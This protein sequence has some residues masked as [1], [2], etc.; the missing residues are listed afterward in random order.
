MRQFALLAAFSCCMFLLADAA[1]AH[2][3]AGAGYVPAGGSTPSWATNYG[4]R[5]AS[6]T[7]GAAQRFTPRTNPTGRTTMQ[8]RGRT[9]MSPRAKKNGTA[10]YWFGAVRLRWEG[11]FLPRPTGGGYESRELAFDEAV[12]G[13][14]GDSSWKLKDRPTLIMVYD[15]SSKKDINLAGLVE[16]NTDFVAASKFFNL[17]RIDRRSIQ[18]KKLAKKFKKEARFLLY[19]AKGVPAGSVRDNGTARKLIAAMKPIISKDYGTKASKAIAN[20]ATVLSRKAW[21]KETIRINEHNVIC[22]D[23]GKKDERVT[24]RLVKLRQALVDLKSKERGLLVRG[25]E[26]AAR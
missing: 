4:I 8:P 26:V 13:L 1:V 16:Q 24:G 23:C 17:L 6:R 5:D 11:T 15:P 7:S 22:A 20:M 2:G 21:I 9:T 3:P 14:G 12:R 18:D 10:R 19:T 25:K